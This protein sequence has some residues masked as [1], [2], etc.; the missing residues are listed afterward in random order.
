[1]W[2]LCCFASITL[3][4]DAGST[5]GRHK[6]NPFLRIWGEKAACCAILSCRES[7]CTTLATFQQDLFFRTSEFIDSILWPNKALKLPSG[8]VQNAFPLHLSRTWSLVFF[9]L[10]DVCT[11]SPA[12][13]TVVANKD[14]PFSIKIS[15]KKTRN[16]LM[17]C[18]LS[19]QGEDDR[20]VNFEDE[21]NLDNVFFV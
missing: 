12:R 21:H 9:R 18:E 17:K 4:S 20:G 2:P 11:A 16:R 15:D 7:N 10:G 19:F 8:F 5:S 13:I 1:M 6:T 14:K 3:V